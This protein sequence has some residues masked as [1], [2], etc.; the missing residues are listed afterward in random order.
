VLTPKPSN[1]D[2]VKNLSWDELNL[3]FTL[4]HGIE[5][6]AVIDNGEDALRFK[7]E[8]WEPETPKRLARALAEVG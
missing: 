5:I 2:D 4:S 7:L 8:A 1:V 6:Q 3:V